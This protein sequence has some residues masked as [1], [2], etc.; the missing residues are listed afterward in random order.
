MLSIHHLIH[1]P[2]RR[3]QG[4][5]AVEMALL[6]PFM[7]LIFAGIVEFGRAFWYY[8]ALAKAT[9]DGAR[10]MSLQPKETIQSV[11]IG[12]A[13]TIVVNAANAAGISPALTSAEV[14]ITCLDATFNTVACSDGTAPENIRVSIS[15]YTIDIGAWIPFFVNAGTTTTYDGVPLAPHTIMR[16]M[17]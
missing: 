17:L 11:G 13:Q 5:A 8:D 2:H 16:H 1:H 12:A 9:R 14:S 7:L 15:G 10:A 6:L 4:V 3:Q